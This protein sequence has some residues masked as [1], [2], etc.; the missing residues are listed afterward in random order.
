M[1]LSIP[2]A[3]RVSVRSYVTELELD[4]APNY[5][6]ARIREQ[7]R[8]QLVERIVNA[9]LKRTPVIGGEEVSLDIVV[10]SPD[11]L[12]ALVQEEAQRLLRS[13]KL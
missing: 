12:L 11:G 13:V 4:S 9:H 6:L 7:M 1:P 2:D 10:T 3:N 5:A 8:E